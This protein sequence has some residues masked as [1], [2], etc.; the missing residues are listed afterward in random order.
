VSAVII[1][2]DITPIIFRGFIVLHF[3]C[4]NYPLLLVRVGPT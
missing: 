2:N 3:D 1:N 4:M